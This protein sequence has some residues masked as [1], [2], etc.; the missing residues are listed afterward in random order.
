MKK[1]VFLMMAFITTTVF[2][3]EGPRLIEIPAKQTPADG[4]SLYVFTVNMGSGKSVVLSIDDVEIG[5]F[6]NGES[7]EIAVSDGTHVVRAYQKKWN[8]RRGT[9]VDDGND[10]LTDTLNGE[11]FPVE[12][13]TK[14]KLKGSNPI[15]LPK[16]IAHVNPK[17]NEVGWLRI[18]YIWV[19]DVRDPY[20]AVFAEFDGK[21]VE[22]TYFNIIAVPTGT[23]T[24]KGV[25]RDAS[26]RVLPDGRLIPR[27]EGTITIEPNSYLTLENFIQKRLRDNF[28]F[29]VLDVSA[30][31]RVGGGFYKE[32]SRAE[33][34]LG[35]TNLTDR[36]GGKVYTGS[37]AGINLGVHDISVPAGKHCALHIAKGIY[38][39]S[40]DGNSVY[41]GNPADEAGRIIMIPEGRH[42]FV[43]DYY[44]EAD[45]ADLKGTGG[46]IGVAFAIDNLAK[47][48]RADKNTLREIN[49]AY[50][51]Y[52]NAEY[53][54]KAIQDEKTRGKPMV[55]ALQ[56]FKDA[57]ASQKAEWFNKNTVIASSNPTNTVNAS[58]A[59]PQGAATYN[60]AINGNPTGP[61]T[62]AEL[63][64]LAQRNEITKD[65]LVWTEGMTEWAPAWTVREFDQVFAAI[66]PPLPPGTR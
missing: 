11:R 35:I 40:F 58:S 33:N 61:F 38:V 16:T 64:V 17:T 47:R 31:V 6:F 12:V 34:D 13:S 14:P 20:T 60:V 1:R 44:E 37:T 66:P 41:W 28:S 8:A 56:P 21:P 62:I 39:R 51:F 26:G 24:M 5:H 36:L 42:T 18:P 30:E 4:Q 2:A 25:W 53:H 29:D 15:K 3:Q 45:L 32:F 27:I 54:L 43:V 48:K 55:I 65:T 46:L 10:R 9:W 57:P 7:A 19:G 22:W 59:N 49:V 50:L 63:K 23:H 52:A